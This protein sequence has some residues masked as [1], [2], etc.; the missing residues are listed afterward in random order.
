MSVFFSVCSLLGIGSSLC[1]ASREN[2]SLPEN[3]FLPCVFWCS[4]S[5]TFDSVLV[6]DAETEVFFNP[7]LRLS[8]GPTVHLGL[9][10]WP[11]SGLAPPPDLGWVVY[12]ACP[13]P[14][15]RAFSLFPTPSCK[16][17]P[18][19]PSSPARLRHL[20]YRGDRV[21]VEFQQGC[22]PPPQPALS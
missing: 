14:K 11:H 18:P 7:P 8:H 9:E 3:V 5:L 19:V 22:H 6:R 16:G 10:A 12:C 4:F 17:L 13:A 15:S 20:F 2:L 21:S 1:L